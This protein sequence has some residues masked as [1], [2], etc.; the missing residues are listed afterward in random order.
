[1][2]TYTSADLS[3]LAG[4][5]P[6]QA[7]HRGLL[8]VEEVEFNKKADVE[9]SAAAVTIDLALAVALTAHA[10]F[11][12]LQ[13]SRFDASVMRMAMSTDDVLPEAIERIISQA[14]WHEGDV[15]ELVLR[16]PAQG[17]IFEWTAEADWYI[18]LCEELVS[19]QTAASLGAREELEDEWAIQNAQMRELLETLAASTEFR[20][21]TIK[22]RKAVAEDIATRKVGD[23]VSPSDFR[24]V[25]KS[26]NE[27]IDRNVLE[28]ERVLGQRIPELVTDLRNYPEWRK[29]KTQVRMR[30]AVVQFLAEKA[31]RYRLGTAFID[32]VMQAALGPDH[33]QLP[34][35]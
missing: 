26:A 13:V 15:E 20:F 4:Q 16:W 6:D 7:N 1:M 23:E 2:T 32:Q 19:A 5:I 17:L 14:S 22:R 34:S 27:Q 35:E 3:L 9:L 30:E 11:V 10:P 24:R 29:A 33:W 12:S 31:D 21:A 8:H 18:G 25:L 28:R